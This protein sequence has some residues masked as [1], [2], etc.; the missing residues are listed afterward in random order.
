[1]PSLARTINLSQGVN[2][3]SVNSGIAVTPTLAAIISP[4]DLVIAKPGISSFLSQT[5]KGP[6]AF[7]CGSRYE[8][9]RPPAFM[10]TSA[11]NLSSGLWSLDKASHPS[12]IKESSSQFMLYLHSL[13]TRAITALESPTFATNIFFPY[14][15]MLI[16][17]DPL[18]K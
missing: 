6:R 3:N 4:K 2:S 16:Q 17:V 9:I 14:V 13:K 15:K 5:L 7:P 1:M 12:S 11:S 8:S 10:M 18:Y